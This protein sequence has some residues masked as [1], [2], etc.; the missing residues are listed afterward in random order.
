MAWEG[1][2]PRGARNRGCDARLDV[3]PVGQTTKPGA[4]PGRRASVPLSATGTTRRPRRVLNRLR[5]ALR[6]PV[7]RN[8]L[9]LYG[10]QIA[11]LVI[12]LLTLPYVAR[13]LEP[14]ALGLVIFAQGFAFALMAFIDWGFGLTG[15]RSV[16]A[17]QDDPDALAE[18]VRRVRGAQIGLVLLSG[19][20]ALTAFLLVPTLR[21]HPEFLVLAYVAAATSG[22]APDWFF[23]GIEQM[24]IM[25]IIQLGFRIVGAALTFVLVKSPADAWMVMALFAASSVGSLLVADVLMYR[26]VE[27]RTPRWRSSLGEIRNGSMIFVA[28]LA[29]TLYTSFN[30]VLLGFLAT[31]ADVAHFG[32]GERLVRVSITLL[33]PIGAAVI[34]RMTALHTAGE[35]ERARRLLVIAVAVC[36]LPAIAITLVLVVFAGPIIRL[37][38]GGA[39]VEDS[40][41]ILRV[42]ALLIPINVTAVVFGVW[43]TTMHRDRLVLVVALTAG[44]ANIILG[45]ILTL[46]F[47][48][49]G[50]AWSVI[51]AEGVAAI[52]ALIA[53]RWGTRRSAAR[54]AETPATEL[55]E[56]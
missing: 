6:H 52:G 4:P 13:V 1:I 19:L 20:F 12:P 8:A 42:L 16:A 11:T 18:V 41:P 45:V 5:T 46:T 48:P 28:T 24:R 29:V 30:V 15:V 9:A 47:G 14:T 32:A 31:S 40:V 38:Y 33:G 3:H 25:A 26:R 21:E 17:V 49:I 54:A 7:S 55:S 56:A 10:V 44:I 2:R 50:M 53:V 34:P 43:L 51:A 23:L 37:I 36:A 39:F 22:L 35:T 27:Y